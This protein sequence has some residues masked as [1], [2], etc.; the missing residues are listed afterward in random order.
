MERGDD[1]GRPL[2]EVR[3]SVEGPEIGVA[4]GTGK[5]KRRYIA[6]E[7]LVQLR[8]SLGMT[9]SAM[10]QALGL[11]QKTYRKAELGR[12]LLPE[13]VEK[14]SRGLEELLGEE[15][16][17]VCKDRAPSRAL[18]VAARVFDGRRLKKFL[19]DRDIALNALT[20]RCKSNWVTLKRAVDG[21]A[22]TA[23][24]R[25]KIKNFL[26]EET[27]VACTFSCPGFSSK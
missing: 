22:V 23:P 16:A 2:E 5:K 20:K 25:E 15:A 1:K 13:T 27:G 7:D 21:K 18:P 12:P 4:R 17:Y 26:E 9:C 14:L 24:V 11:S 19:K 8:E 10:C 6:H 3:C